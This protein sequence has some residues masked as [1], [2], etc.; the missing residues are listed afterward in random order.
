MD[1]GATVSSRAH[2]FTVAEYHRMAE[3]GILNEDSRCE[4]IGGV[5]VDMA[6]VGAAHIG[7]VTRLIRLLPGI[8]DGRASFTV[9]NALRLDDGSEPEPDVVILKPRADDYERIAPGGSDALLVIEVADSS[10]R[11]DREIKAPLYAESGIPELWIVDIASR[12]VEV[13]R[14]PHAGRYTEVRRVEAD[15][16]LDMVAVPGAVLPAGEL[17]RPVS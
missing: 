15:G 2:R 5:I 10:L 9:Q 12:N 7:F 3:A 4:L 6:P 1:G 13:F 16:V 8:L 11:D 14:K 17:L